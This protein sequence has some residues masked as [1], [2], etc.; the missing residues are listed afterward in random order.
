[1]TMNDLVFAL[2]KIILLLNGLSEFISGNYDFITSNYK[3]KVRI[4][5]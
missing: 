5:R 1:M 3:K 2:I 4:V